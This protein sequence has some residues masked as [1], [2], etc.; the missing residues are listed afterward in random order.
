MEVNRIHLAAIQEI[1]LV[2]GHIKTSVV[3][4]QVLLEI[5]GHPPLRAMDRKAET[6]ATA[7]QTRE[8]PHHQ[9]TTD[10]HQAGQVLSSEEHPVPSLDKD[11][12]P[13]SPAVP[14]PQLAAFLKTLDQ[15]PHLLNN[16][17]FLHLWITRHGLLP[18]LTSNHHRPAPSMAHRPYRNTHR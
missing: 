4:D 14:S 5:V 12:A 6:E 17:P 15:P 10:H 18:H 3:L 11:L 13:S 2:T 16:E 1:D 7:H 9:P 8:V